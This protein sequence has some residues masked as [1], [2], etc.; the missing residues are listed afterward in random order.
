MAG[1]FTEVDSDIQK[2]RAL[3]NEINAV[4]TQ[5]KS[6]DIRVNLDIKEALEA[7]IQSLTK[8]YHDLAEKVV[9]TEGRIIRS[10]QN[11]IEA[12]KK[13]TDAQ[14]KMAKM[15]APG[16]SQQSGG[17][18]PVATQ[19]VIIQNSAIQAQARAY[20]ELKGQIDAVLGTRGQNIKRMLEE[21]NAIRIINAE[22]TRIN[23][24][25]GE[26]GVLSAAQKQRLEQLNSSLLTHKAALSEVRQALSNNVKLDNAAMTSMNGLSQSLSRMRVAYR[27]LTEE[28]RGSTFGKELL[29]SIQQ[30]DAKLKE[31]DATIGNHQRNVGNYASGWNGL[32]MSIQQIGR[33][34]P[35]LAYGPKVFFSAISNNLPILS[36]EIKRARN[37]YEMLKK[38]GQSAVPVWKQIISSL[39]S[40]QSAL[41]VGITLLTLY[42]DKLVDWASGLFKAKEALSETYMETEKFQKSVSQSVGKVLTTIEKLSKAWI[43]LGD[44]IKSKEKFILDYKSELDSTGIAINNVADAENLLSKNKDDFISAIIE[45]AKATAVMDIAAKE[46]EKYIQ[47]MLEADAKAEKGVSLGDKFKSWVARS[48]AGNDLS[49]TLQNADLSPEAF[50]REGEDKLRKEAEKHKTSTIDLIK[51]FLG[52]DA[53][54]NEEIST[55]GGKSRDMLVANSIEAIEAVIA[56]KREALKKVTNRKDYL[57]I[58]AEIK[59]E[60]SKLDAITGST[61]QEAERLRKENEKYHFLL[62]KQKLEQ[63]RKVQDLENLLEQSEIDRMDDRAERAIRQRELNNKKEIQAI[64]RQKED[65]INAII[66]DARDKFNAEEELKA[67]KDKNYKKRSFDASSVSVDSSKYDAVIENT[68]KRQEYDIYKAEADAMR[69]FLREYGTFQQ[70][71]LAIAKEYAEKIRKSQN[72]GERRMLEKQ[73]DAALLGVDVKS[74]KQNIDWQSVFGDLGSM[75]RD[76]IQPTIDNLKRI[77]QSDEFKNSSV[78][79]QQRIYDILTQ[80]ER[81]SG[82]LE[83]DMFKDV[84]R[85]L[86]LYRNSLNAYNEA[87]E[88]EIKAAERL[89]EA[90]ERLRIA[91]ANGGDVSYAQKEV[92][93]AQESL[94]QASESVKNL[95]E[96]ASENAEALRGSSEK[97]KGAIEGLA[98]GLDKF[99]SGSLSQ[100]FDGF[101]DIGKSLGGKLG[102]A[103]ADIDPTGI[104]GGVL[105]ILDILKDGVSDIF[106]SLQDLLYGA[107]EGVLNDLFSGDIIMKP[108]KNGMEHIG[109]IL[110]TITFGGFNSW[111]ASSNAKEVAETTERLTSSNE[112]LKN[113]VDKL[114]DEMSKSGGWKAI[115]AAKQAEKDQ[116]TINRQT[117]DILRAQMGYHGA[118]HSNEYYW[119]LDRRDYAVLNKTLSDYAKKNDKKESRVGSLTDIY[120]LSPE[121]MDYIRTYNIE[122]WKKMLEQGKYNK[123]EYWEQYAN[124]AGK[125]EEITDSL[126]NTL[127]QISFD[128]LRSSF[129]DSL[130]DMDKSAQDFADDFQNYMMKAILNAKISDLLDKDLWDFYNKWAEFSKSGGTLDSWEKKELSKMW[131]DITKRGLSIRDEVASF[132]GYGKST[133]SQDS[134][135]RGFGTEMTHEDAGEL[136]GRFTALQVTGEEVLT[137]SVLTN[138]WLAKIHA[139]MAA[140]NIPDIAGQSREIINS[141]YQ[142]NI[143]I[144]FPA[145]EFRVLSDRIASVE[146][147]VTDMRDLQVERSLDTHEI[148]SG[149]QIIAKNSPMMLNAAEDI[150]RNTSK[151]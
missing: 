67:K 36:D 57:K 43:K 55:A 8:Q 79:D 12:T 119:G 26:H 88:R 53:K 129:V 41:T 39:F 42:G 59:A 121:E 95:S 72:E 100:A 90:H 111:F 126:K 64:E 33:E 65:Y 77:T 145:E 108:I 20:D 66:Q 13:I 133:S 58:E 86:E 76:Q 115:D 97:A 25:K 82:T 142:P 45:K 50:A 69:N 141:S 128:S 47:K 135:K 60:Q 105:S 120:G 32:S 48:A 83:K 70:Q 29:R 9:Q 94:N 71:K 109:N 1:I 112:R 61:K 10:T 136:S 144:N 16:A 146:R 116:K 101:K 7:R 73:R 74:A 89:V 84:A 114:K 104:I 4:K 22:I 54:S 62:D 98:I 127:T 148:G 107:I 14:E 140:D 27:E 117:M 15:S 103:I 134:T 80:L 137:Q 85:D 23:K 92:D 37:E 31:L 122:M 131:D 96:K 35:A 3:K 17:S 150:K 123:G 18:Q 75:L 143:R 21:Q 87:Q 118:H 49:G 40:W 34:M 130:M 24:T 11:I 132:T 149:V 6:I 124:L 52:I 147:V 99:R 106:V 63:F 38:S 68:K 110:N 19:A 151:L 113:A 56:S 51:K 2:L 46:Y 78:E 138:E 28:E 5:L 44:D 102:D 81:Q 91:Q 125:L 30:A 93:E 139:K